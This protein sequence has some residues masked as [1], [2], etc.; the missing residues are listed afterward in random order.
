MKIEWVLVNG[1]E[2]NQDEEYAAD[3]WLFDELSGRWLD[4]DKVIEARSEDTG[5]MEKELDMFV[6]ATWEECVKETGRPPI[7]IKWVDVDK[8]TVQNQIIR[9]R[10]VAR[11]F[12][13]KGES[14]RSDLFAAMPLLEAKRMLFRIAVRRCREKSCEMYKI[15]LIDVKKAH[16]NGEVP[17]DEKVFVLLP[18]EA[19]RGVA[20]LKRWLCGMRPAAKAWEEHYATQLTNEGGFR[21]ASQPPPSFG[22]RGGT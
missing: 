19:G 15:M 3:E 17:E 18:S 8:G 20:R 7:S 10:L 21:R 11:D 12:R 5:Y 2:V 14:D 1:L 4:V 13:V 9:S 22:N 6:P 16:L